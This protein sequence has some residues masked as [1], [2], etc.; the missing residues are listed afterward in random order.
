MRSITPS[1]GLISCAEISTAISCSRVMRASSATTSWALRRSRFAS[2]S[3]SSSSRGRP[4]SAWAIRIRCCSPPE[5]RP[6]RVSA[7]PRGVDRLEHLLD[8]RATGAGGPRHPEPV[9]VQ[10][11]PHEIA[12]AHRQIRVEQELLRD[13]ADRALPFALV[14]VARRTNRRPPRVDRRPGGLDLRSGRSP[15]WAPAAR[16]SPGT[17]SSC[18]PRSIRSAP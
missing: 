13:V 11:E 10:A 3:S 1:S 6:T 17:A 4:I 15:R 8:Q 16:G 18:P 5:S 7:K 12:R 9:G 2:G 14:G